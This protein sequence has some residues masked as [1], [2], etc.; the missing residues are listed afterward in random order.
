MDK[1]LIAIDEDILRWGNIVLIFFVVVCDF[2]LLVYK[3]QAFLL[4][5]E[6]VIIITVHR[7]LDRNF[8][9]VA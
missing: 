9:F 5:S 1:V 3:K 8:S 2:N 4:L 6:V 7:I